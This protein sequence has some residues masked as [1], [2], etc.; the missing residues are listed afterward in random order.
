MSKGDR[1]F[2]PPW[3]LYGERFNIPMNWL[4]VLGTAELPHID[5]SVR[6]QFHAKVSWLQVFKT[7]EEPLEF[8]FPRKGPIDT[9]SQ[10]MDGGIEQPLSS[11]FRVLSIARIL[12]N[13]WD[14]SSIENALPIVLG[15][16]S[17][18]K[19]QI[20]SCECQTNRFG[21]PLQASQPLRQEHHVGC[22]HWCHWAWRDD[23]AMVVRNGQD[24]LPLLMLVARVTDPISPFLATVLVPSPW[25]TRT[26]SF[27]S[28]ERCPTLAINARW[29]DPSS[30]HLAKAR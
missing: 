17:R 26:S 2:Q 1:G 15:I 9:G 28:S 25:R 6:H 14:Q 7:Q 4:R 19:I 13:V 22:V 18:V 8:V 21:D 12:L 20:G 10:G 5:Q 24:L 23:I 3:Q 11:L 29:S 16:E 27:F 30:A